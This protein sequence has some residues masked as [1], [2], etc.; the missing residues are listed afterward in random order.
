MAAEL[1]KEPDLLLLDEPTNHLDLEGVLYLE[2]LLQSAPFPFIV[3]SHDRSFLEN[4]SNRTIELN[5]LYKDGF[6]SVK[7]PYSQ[8]L[9]QR[10]EYVAAQNNEQQA[11]ASKVRR[12]IAWLQRG[13]RA[14]QTK[15]QA[16]I[17]DA[18]KLID[19]LE[20]VK[21]RNSL[22]AAAD[23]SFSASGRRTKELLVCKGIKKSFSGKLLFSNLDLTLAPG[24]KL[25]LMGTNGS[26]KTTLLKVLADMLSTD[27]GTI[28]RADGLQNCLV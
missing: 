7:G 8:F 12:E 23:I 27:G 3:V 16:R 9:E 28:K 11:L 26:G 15:S 6:L 24:Q 25:G 21:A 10:Q 17:R 1:V 14:R 18:G 5:P 19:D 2:S 22:T 20:E 4:I 13:A